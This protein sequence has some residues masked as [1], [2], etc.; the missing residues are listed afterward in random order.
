[1]LPP[2]CRRAR[3]RARV[4]DR[5]SGRVSGRV[6]SPS[7]LSALQRGFHRTGEVD[8]RA[9]LRITAA[10][11]CV[12]IKHGND[13]IT[14]YKL[15]RIHV[16]REKRKHLHTSVCAT[17]LGPALFEC[18]SANTPLGVAVTYRFKASSLN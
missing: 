1:M 6:V 17:C 15:S 12:Q 2:A 5:V 16:L 13:V 14:Y 9:S 11:S 4:R 7:W 3:V 8:D 10:R 18:Q